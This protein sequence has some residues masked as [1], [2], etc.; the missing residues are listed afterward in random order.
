M[1]RPLGT[2]TIPPGGSNNNTTATPATLDLSDFSTMDTVIE[3][4][5][6]NLDVTYEQ[7]GDSPGA[8]GVTIDVDP[9]DETVLVHFEDG[10]STRADVE[11][12][13][14]ALAGDDKIIR[15]KTP[16]SSVGALTV[17]G[18][19][20]GPEDLTG[21]GGFGLPVI[22]TAIDV[23]TGDSDITVRVMPDLTGY[24]PLAP[25]DYNPTATPSSVAA[26]ED[27]EPIDAGFIRHLS[28]GDYGC[29]SVV[30]CYNGGAS[31][32]TVKI[33]AAER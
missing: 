14:S 19:E 2:I 30:A 31:E 6:G 25:G 18:D 24:D 8:G 17:A 9:E 11:A 28:L 20:F 21:G 10:V 4:V 7:A 32:A 27:D 3:A 5:P 1:Q 29:P 23:F 33:Y 22:G 26:T 13:I 15:V 12:A 16:G